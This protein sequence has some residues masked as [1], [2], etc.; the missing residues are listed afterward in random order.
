MMLLGCV[1]FLCNAWNL[2]TC[3]ENS[4]VNNRLQILKI[5]DSPI[6]LHQDVKVI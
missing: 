1:V 4:A 2:S 5:L 6:F 3:I